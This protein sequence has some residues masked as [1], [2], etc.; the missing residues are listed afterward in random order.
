MATDFL[1]IHYRYLLIR[2]YTS[3]TWCVSTA[4]RKQTVLQSDPTMCPNIF[5]V[6][7]EVNF[8][9][10]KINEQ[11]LEL[12][13]LLLTLSYQRLSLSLHC[14]FQWCKCVQYSCLCLK[15][16]PISWNYSLFVNLN[17]NTYAENKYIVEDKNGLTTEDVNPRKISTQPYRNMLRS[18][19]SKQDDVYLT[20]SSNAS[21]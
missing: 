21:L 8:K 4:T 1:S 17:W 9:I 3:A 5:L 14:M 7:T 19:D 12:A 10:E 16:V 6:H 15:T 20:L 2:H 18:S 13:I 11:I